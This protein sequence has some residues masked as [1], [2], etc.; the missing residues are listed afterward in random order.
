MQ[1][2][3]HDP[4]EIIETPSLYGSDCLSRSFSPELP[5]SRMVVSAV[6]LST[7]HF[8]ILQHS[9]LHTT[10]PN[11]APV[12]VRTCDTGSDGLWANYEGDGGAARGRS[13]EGST[14]LWSA[15]LR[16]MI[17]PPRNWRIRW[18]AST[19]LGQ[20]VAYPSLVVEALR[21]WSICGLLGAQ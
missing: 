3:S 9:P 21:L 5:T 1:P 15:L 4:R 19:S 8:H 10:L 18:F 16:S 11:R 20:T 17:S 12:K 14:V 2:P 6:R 13:G 7:S